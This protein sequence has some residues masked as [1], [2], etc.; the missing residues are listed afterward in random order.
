[1][2]VVYWENSFNRRK[3]LIM[4]GWGVDAEQGDLFERI[5]AVKGDT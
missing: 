4:K 5:S 3:G 2:I 1:M